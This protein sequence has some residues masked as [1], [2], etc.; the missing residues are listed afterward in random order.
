MMQNGDGQTENGASR[1]RSFL[2]PSDAMDR[3]VVSLTVVHGYA[4]LAR[5]RIRR[6][7]TSGCEDLEQALAR[8]EEAT[9]A[10]AAELWVIMGAI[11]RPRDDTNP[12]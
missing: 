8:M 10:I 11:S 1:E 2:V 5:R 7:G 6:D 4:Q 9:R 12:D 3:I